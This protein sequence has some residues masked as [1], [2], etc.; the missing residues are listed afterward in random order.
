MG[1]YTQSQPWDEKIPGITDSFGGMTPRPKRGLLGALLGI[2]DQSGEWS[3]RTPIDGTSTPTS[4]VTHRVDD[5]I[6]RTPRG[7]QGPQG[8]QP[9]ADDHLA[10]MQAEYDA[11]APQPKRPSLRDLITQKISG[12]QPTEGQNPS[13][14]QIGR[15]GLA[16]LVTQGLP[17]AAG[18]AFGGR[19]G[20]I[21]AGQAEQAQ[22]IR[23]QQNRQF[24]EQQRNQQ[25]GR[26]LQEIEAE[27]RTQE[28]ERAS[29]ARLK[30]QMMMENDR[31][32]QQ[33][34]MQDRKDAAAQDRLDQT[35]RQQ[36]DAL[37]QRLQQQN[38]QFNQRQQNKP[39]VGTWQFGTDNDGNPALFNSK[40]GRVRPGPAGFHPR[41]EKPTADEQRRADLANNMSENLDALEEIVK[42]RPDLFGPVAG[43]WSSLKGAIGTGDKDIAQL[44][45]IKEQMGMAMVGA[46]AMRNA[47][48][49]ETAGNAILN[50]MNNQPEAILSAIQAARN[51][52]QTFQQDAQRAKG[53]V[54]VPTGGRPSLKQ[55]MQ[56]KVLVEGKDF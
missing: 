19:E 54:T 6:N 4:S 11:L 49:V 36:Q 23:D 38:E 50:N 37:D 33:N 29:D 1:A 25:R 31:F 9:T 30:Q 47:Q 7:A 2:G 35:L 32:N 12:P 26:L 10:R 3:E 46:H 52:L 13:L 8:S 14:G 53:G 42:R 22:Q 39:E 15:R 43:R 45:T 18:L 34:Q 48:H 17:L 16:G 55:Q 56:P 44:K 51:S 28:M 5:E 20:M 40:T 24:E 27:R 21:G 41:S